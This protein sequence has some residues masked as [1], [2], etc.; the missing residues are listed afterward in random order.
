MSLYFPECAQCGHHVIF[1]NVAITTYAG[2]HMQISVVDLPADGVVDWHQHANEQMGMLVSGRA[3]FH[4]GDEVKELRAGDIY[5]IPAN[6]RHKVVPVGGSGQ[7][8]DF[9]YPIRD[10]YR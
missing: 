3:L 9:F 6:V 10:E 2:D 8:V 7:A 4:I 1:G 5:F